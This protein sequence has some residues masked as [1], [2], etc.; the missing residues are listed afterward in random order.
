MKE[1]VQELI[2]NNDIY[3]FGNLFLNN[4]D[5]LFVKYEYAKLLSKNNFKP[6]AKNL[7]EELI[8][9][10]YEAQARI[11]ISKIEKEFGNIEKA[12]E[13]L[14]LVKN[15]NKYVEIALLELGKIEYEQGNYKEA[16]TYFNFFIEN[17]IE[18]KNYAI[19]ELAKLE[20]T[21]GKTNKS[22]ELLNSLIGTNFDL[23]A[24]LMLCHLYIK[25]NKYEDAFKYFYD[26]K[27]DNISNSTKIKL[28]LILSKHLNIF[29]DFDYDIFYTYTNN[30][31]MNYKEDKAI[32]YIRLNHTKREL[33]SFKDSIN[34]EELFYKIKNNLNRDNIIRRF[35]LADTYYFDYEPIGNNNENRLKVVTLPGTNKIL[36][37]YPVKD[38][39]FYAK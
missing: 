11:Q 6:I 38:K 3:G 32:D 15:P 23:T 20:Y 12:K 33:E 26:I 21:L 36:T 31:I 10:R 18:S 35:E 8:C 37:L 30:Q 22:I 39:D 5:D 16:K 7:F 14:K 9:T 19:I 13:Q 17:N 2:S 25:E 4:S 34:I 28:T 1:T 29:F 27:N 24:K